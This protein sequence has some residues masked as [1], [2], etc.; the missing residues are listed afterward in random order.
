MILL[1]LGVP[2]Y[3]R[4]PVISHTIY[5][6]TA[7]ALCEH[8]QILQRRAELT[9]A[10]RRRQCDGDKRVYLGEV[11]VVLE[12]QGDVSIDVNLLLSINIHWTHLLP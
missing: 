7:P 6:L 5:H 10:H 8:G 4:N 2:S 1:V 12:R 3:S 11:E 9:S